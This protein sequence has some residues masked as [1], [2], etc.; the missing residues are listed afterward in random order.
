MSTTMTR[1]PSQ[2]AEAVE[3]LLQHHLYGPRLEPDLTV[4]Q[5][6]HGTWD[7]HLT[8]DGHYTYREDAEDTIPL[9]RDPLIRAQ[10]AHR[11]ESEVPRRCPTCGAPAFYLSGADRH[12]HEDGSDNDKCW[13]AILRGEV[14]LP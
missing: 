11:V 13:L 10:V 12:F 5:N 1:N 6:E 4:E 2:L 7:V 9:W 8:L 14:S 3:D